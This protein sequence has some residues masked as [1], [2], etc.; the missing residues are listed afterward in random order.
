MPWDAGTY[1]DSEV[2]ELWDVLCE[3]Y[4][5]D[6]LASAAAQQVRC[7]VLCPLYSTPAQIRDSKEALIEVMGADEAVTI[8]AKHPA[9]LTCGSDVLYA[10]PDEIRRLASLRS[11]LDRIPPAVLLGSV[12]AIT[13]AV[14]GKIALIQLGYAD[15]V[16]F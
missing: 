10:D 11:V 15:R 2:E 8:M 13:A 12:L 3:A 9:I 6:D 16:S 1:M 7:S 4:G 14:G 5:S